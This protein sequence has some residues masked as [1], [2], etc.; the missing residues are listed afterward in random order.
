MGTEATGHVHSHSHGELHSHIPLSGPLSGNMLR[1]LE[2]AVLATGLLVAG[3][4]VAGTV[5]GSL[6]VVGDGIHNLSDLP[7]LLISWF[8]V[9]MANRPPTREKTYGYHR[10]G[11]LAAFTNSLLLVGVSVFLFYAAIGRLVVPVPVHT[12][13]MILM[14]LVALAVNGG[15]TLA[16]VR[17]RRDLNLRSVL[18]HNAGDALSNVG[19]LVGAVLI[20]WTGAAWIDPLLGMAIGGLVVWSSAG[21]LRESSHIL[22]EGLPRGIHLEAVARAMLGVAG[23]QEVHDIHIWTLGTDLLALSCHVRIPDMHMEESEKILAG[24]REILDHDFHITHTTIQFE[25][26][27]PPATAEFI[28]PAPFKTP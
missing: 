5:A 13:V 1:V 6:A 22:L 8:A 26:A 3:E 4:L 15:I 28:M 10:A 11:I 18:I 19:I 12:G 23:V 24:V 7:T 9:R 20:A 2:G 17:G 21:I 16:L 14:S 25:R 27:G